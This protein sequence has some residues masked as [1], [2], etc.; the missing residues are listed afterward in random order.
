MK[1]ICLGVVLMLASA[2]LT[3]DSQIIP[4]VD[5]SDPLLIT[6][7]KIEFVDD[8]RP[9]AVVEVE[10]QTAAAIDVDAVQLNITRF[11]TRSEAEQ[12][13]R[14]V[15]DCGRV[16]HVDHQPGDPHQVI[17]AHARQVVT[18]SLEGLCQHNREHEHFFVTLARLQGFHAREPAWVR[19]PAE[20][21]RLLAAA[22]PHP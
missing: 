12:R 18:V 3:A 16:G 20:L 4:L 21:V 2:G 17:A 19:E 7:A 11:Y 22:Q 15:W 8:E 5:P 14:Q 13:G 10:N 1:Q 9:V 6:N